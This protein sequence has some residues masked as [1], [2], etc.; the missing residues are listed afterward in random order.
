MHQW[1]NIIISWGYS[2]MPGSVYMLIYVPHVQT[3]ADQLASP[4]STVPLEWIQDQ[5]TY[6]WNGSKARPHTPGM[7]PRPDHIPLEWIHGQT[8]G[9]LQATDN[10]LCHAHWVQRDHAHTVLP[11]ERM[12]V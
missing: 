9:H 10:S 5:T 1:T 6:P 4:Y 3:N 2:M 7:D 11:V 8:T 12:E